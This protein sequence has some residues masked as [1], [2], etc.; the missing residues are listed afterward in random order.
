VS[1]R[2]LDFQLKELVTEF[3]PQTQAHEQ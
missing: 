1:I 3:N 2:V